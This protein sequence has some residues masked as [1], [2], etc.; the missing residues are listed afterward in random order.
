MCVEGQGMSICVIHQGMNFIVPLN[1]LLHQKKKNKDQILSLSELE[2]VPT[3]SKW[4]SF[5]N[6]VGPFRALI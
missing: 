4:K 5:M 2:L 1:F 3:E 6:H